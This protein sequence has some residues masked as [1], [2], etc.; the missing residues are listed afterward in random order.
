[1]KIDVFQ[2]ISYA[3]WLIMVTKMVEIRRERMK[4]IQISYMW[5][6]RDKL[7]ENS[8]NSSENEGKETEKKI[9]HKYWLHFNMENTSNPDRRDRVFNIEHTNFSIRKKKSNVQW[10]DTETRRFSALNRITSYISS[11]CKR[12]SRVNKSANLHFHFHFPR[13]QNLVCLCIIFINERL[14]II[15]RA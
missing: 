15:D 6:S 14:F 1:M 5:L 10:N 9:R 3:T 7:K 4:K 13:N 12:D 11:S 8:S 2:L